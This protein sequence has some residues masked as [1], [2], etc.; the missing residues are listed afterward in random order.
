MG[1]K[2][3]NIEEKVYTN[4]ESQEIVANEKVEDNIIEER[5]KRKKKI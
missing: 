1:E 3:E 5:T 2:E 4:E